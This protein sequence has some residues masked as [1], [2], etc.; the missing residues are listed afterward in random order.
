VSF[1][2]ARLDDQFVTFDGVTPGVRLRVRLLE[3]H[4]Y[5]RHSKIT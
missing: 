5:R 4:L 1:G 2:A 3:R